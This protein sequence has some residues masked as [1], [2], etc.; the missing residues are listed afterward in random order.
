MEV[1]A[2]LRDDPRTAGIPAAFLTSRAQPQEVRSY[3]EMGAVDVI[4]KPFDAMTLPG[5]V[6]QIL[7]RLRG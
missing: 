2:A 4:A 5:R 6:G 1:F 3:L 7:D